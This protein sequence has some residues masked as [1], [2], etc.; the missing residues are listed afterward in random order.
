MRTNL[1][2]A[3]SSMSRSGLMRQAPPQYYKSDNQKDRHWKSRPDAK[4][5]YSNEEDY[6][7]N[8]TNAEQAINAT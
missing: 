8:N 3:Q 2:E 6:T 1:L 4:R 5:H 7:A